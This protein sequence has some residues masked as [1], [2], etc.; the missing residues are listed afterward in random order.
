[1]FSSHKPYFVFDGVPKRGVRQIM[2]QT[3]EPNNRPAFTDEN[4]QL[5]RREGLLAVLRRA[6]A[7]SSVA[8]PETIDDGI[9]QLVHLLEYSDDVVNPSM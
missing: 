9:H 1:M 5:A 2:K 7:Q 4:C 8:S 3:Y 6:N